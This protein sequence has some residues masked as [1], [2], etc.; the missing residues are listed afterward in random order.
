MA[1]STVVATVLVLVPWTLH[2]LDRF[3][4][5]VLMSTNTGGTL[6]A[7]NCPPMTYGGDLIGS[8]HIACNI[9]LARTEADLDRSQHD[10]E[11]RAIAIENTRDNL[12][13]LPATVAARHGRTLGVF[14]PAQT[15]DIAAYW[16]GSAHW[17]VWAW[18]ASFWLLAP[19]AVYGSVLLRRS[20]TFQWPLVAPVVVA[21]VV[22]AAYGEPRYHTP[23][24]LGLVVLAAVAAERL[25]RRTP[26]GRP[27]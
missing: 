5:P 21:L 12:G 23:A 6:L 9:R 25:I 2:N 20:R 18:V 13:R 1:A 14:R 16:M 26:L 17:P 3:E 24:D 19:L 27:R 8:Y 22:T 15:V 11:S 4:E 7:G 10:I